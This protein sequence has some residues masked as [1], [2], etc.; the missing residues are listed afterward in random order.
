M[1]GDKLDKFMGSSPFSK[2]T[3]IKEI[4]QSP[5]IKM[6]LCQWYIE[7]SHIGSQN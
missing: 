1:V 3:H 7:L 4:T 2:H 5:G 6:S